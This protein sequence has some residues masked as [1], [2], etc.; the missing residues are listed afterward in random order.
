M[1]ELIAPFPRPIALAVTLILT[2]S[3]PLCAQF[4]PE[5]EYFFRIYYNS[6][7]LMQ[8]EARAVGLRIDT[9][10]DT[11]VEANSHV[12]L[13]TIEGFENIVLQDGLNE[14]DFAFAGVAGIEGLP[15][16]Y[17]R[18]HYVIDLSQ[19]ENAL[20]FLINSL[21]QVFTYPVEIADDPHPERGA[22]KGLTAE[23]TVI[24]T[25]GCVQSS[26]GSGLLVCV[27]FSMGGS[28]PESSVRLQKVSAQLE[29]NKTAS[30]IVLNNH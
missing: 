20:V 17:Y 6:R 10:V 26:S 25:Q 3:G 9:D 4:A 11:L 30:Q 24:M 13:A 5:Q 27:T 7:V 8:N 28:D 2:G 23:G 29:V 16:G 15:D 1:K 18:L 19:P 14:F 22:R 12:L 21:G